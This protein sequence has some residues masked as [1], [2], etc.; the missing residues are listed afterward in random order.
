MPFKCLVAPIGPQLH[1]EVSEEAGF[2]FREVGAGR[3][4]GP[5]L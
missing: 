5:G 1:A 4:D 2:Q 3:H